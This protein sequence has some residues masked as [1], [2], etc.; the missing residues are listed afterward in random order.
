MHVLCT[1]IF[2]LSPAKTLKSV[3]NA[4]VKATSPTEALAGKA[5]SVL[6]ELQALTPAQLKSL[7]KVS[8]AI[9]KC[10]LLCK[11]CQQVHTLQMERQSL[12]AADDESC[13]PGSERCSGSCRY[14][15]NYER[16][17][18]WANQVAVPAALAFDGPAYKGLQADDMDDASLQYLQRH[19]RILCGLYGILRPLDAL[20]PY[21]HGSF[22]KLR[23]R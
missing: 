23:R 6:T 1:M 7:L 16:Y 4:V 19:L 2:L 8:D 14:R 20:K 3:Q 13:R 5:Q 21:R 15:L 12:R 17:H 22:P 11:L 18:S 10:A 9:A